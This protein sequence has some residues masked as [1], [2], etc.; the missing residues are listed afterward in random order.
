MILIAESGSTKTN[1]LTQN[2]YTLETIGLNPLFMTTEDISKELM[3]YPEFLSLT[4]Q[5]HAVFFYGASCSSDERKKRVSDALRQFFTKAVTVAVDHDLKAAA[6]ATFDGRKAI[7]CIL[8]T[9][10]NS[11][12]F[13]GKEIYQGVP[14]VGYI[15]G[16]EGGG[17]YF[18][19]ILLA[20][21]LYQELPEA[22]DRILR[23]QYGLNKEIILENVYRRPQVNVYLA[24]FAKVMKDSTDRDYMN[25]L[26]QEGFRD[27]FQHHIAC[28]ENYRNYPVHFVGSIAH[29][30]REALQNIATEFGCELGN[31]VHQ[32]AGRLLEWHLKNEGK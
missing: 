22:T 28:Y 21:F 2:G 24:S 5:I 12:L 18:G 31:V 19:K 15:L 4:S 16:D 6:L 14:A 17:A 26:A 30:F 27:F 29:H 8:G 10:S 32:P 25:T 7:A 9:G 23:E 3:K 11:C 13:D 20:R 1:W